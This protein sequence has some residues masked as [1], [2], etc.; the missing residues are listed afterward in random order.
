MVM[1]EIVRAQQCLHGYDGGHRLLTASVRL[2]PERLRVLQVMSDISGHAMSEGF[3]SYLTAYPLGEWYAF[4][5]TWEAPEM[6]RPGCVWTHTILLPQSEPVT[7]LGALLPLFARPTGT[8]TDATTFSKAI[9]INSEAAMRIRD[10]SERETRQAMIHA[11]FDT[12]LPLL[13]GV[14]SSDV[15]ERSFIAIWRLQPKRMRYNMSFCTGSL[16]VRRL[17][18]KPLLDAF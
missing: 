4:A 9:E 3:K 10:L 1:A 5:R 12:D 15:V 2:V 7:D 18:E 14:D 16:D 17:A 13:V 8:T 11:Y 6:P